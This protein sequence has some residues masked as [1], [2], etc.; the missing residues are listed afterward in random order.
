LQ[1]YY[2]SCRSSEKL[3]QLTRIISLETSQKQS[4]HFIVYFATR[5]CVDYF[6]KVLPSLTSQKP[7]FYSLH[8]NI[9]PT[10][11]TRTLNAFS[12]AI[13]S[14]SSPSILLTTDVAARGLDIPNVDIIIQF[15]PLTDSKSF[16]HRC[17]RT[18][19]AGRTNAASILLAKR[20]SAF[21]DFL[22]VQKKTAC[23]NGIGNL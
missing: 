20:K 5:T 17:G 7:T 8:G 10:A 1:N 19:R 14:P 9:S 22:S 13:P 16:S 2:I 12:S 4:S 18:A 15:N 23:R 6:Y 21:C 3:V 11:R